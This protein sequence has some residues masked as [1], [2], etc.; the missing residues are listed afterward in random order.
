M[1]LR[2]WT[3]LPLCLVASA[4]AAAS[5][6]E[7][8]SHG[9]QALQRGVYEV[10]LSATE[11]PEAP[12]TPAECKVEF[13]RPDKSTVQVPAFYDGGTVFRARAYCDQVGRWRWRSSST[14]PGLGGRSGSFKTIRSELPGKLR[15]HPTDL[16][17]F[18]YDNGDWFLH[19]GDTGYRYLAASEPQWR[20]YIDQAAEMGA[21]KIRAWFCGADTKTSVLLTENRDAL[22]LDFWQEMDRRLRYALQ[23]HPHIIFQVIPF[24]DDA[25]EVRRYRSGDAMA[26]LI[27]AYAQARFSALPNVTW[28]A[29]NDLILGTG[30]ETGHRQAPV[31]AV[32]AICADMAAREPWGTLITNHQARFTGYSF[33][34]SSWSDITTLED[35][36]QVDGRLVL[37][38]RSRS[39]AP[40]IIDE[41]RYEHHREPAH[42]RYFFRRLMWGNLLSGGHATYDGLRTWE[43]Y[44]GDL[45]GVQ[46]Y[47]DACAA[48]KLAEGAHDFRA[49]HQFFEDAKLTLAGMVPDDAFVGGEPLLRKCIRDDH[50]IIVYLANPSGMEPGTDAEGTGI[51]E[52]S[53]VL[54]EGDWDSRWFDPGTGTY[55]DGPVVNGRADLT[56]PGSGDWVLLLVSR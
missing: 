8:V 53:L 9:R 55:S 12:W 44:D 10:V 56:A 38:Y 50:T 5:I 41:D 17:Q 35:M 28:C 13:R 15:I 24:G 23:A 11:P 32:E 26:R 22:A 51:P 14:V 39:A 6:T 3:V 18:A 37:E 21:T 29:S 52:V 42:K 20:E 54:P 19:I 16:W 40:V 48:G 27:A 30:E 33:T 43:P 46:G 31:A 45:R 2:C 34:Q 4:P 49:I 36:D 1:V 47:Y 25:A 7:A